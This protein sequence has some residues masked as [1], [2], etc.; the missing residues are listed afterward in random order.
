MPTKYEGLDFLDSIFTELNP[1]VS[2][3]LPL[4][5]Y[6]TEKEIQEFRDIFD[7]LGRIRYFDYQR[8]QAQ[9][10]DEKAFYN[11]Y[12]T[13]LATYLYL[14]LGRFTIIEDVENLIVDDPLK[15]FVFLGICQKF[16]EILQC[17]R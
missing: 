11:A 7:T 1:P 6:G 9:G 8:K 15:A 14:K 12:R 5:F 3:T 17:E 4:S 2:S 13:D 16:R 10:V